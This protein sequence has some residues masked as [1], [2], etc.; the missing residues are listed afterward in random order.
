[1]A[2]ALQHEHDQSSNGGSTPWLDSPRTI[3]LGLIFGVVF[4]FLLQKGGVAKFDILIGVLLLEDFTVIKVMM[5]A[6]VVGLLGVPLLRQLGLLELHIKPTILG[7]NIVGGLIFG[8]GFALLAYCSGTDA[9][10][11]GQGNL[12]ALTGMA[13]MLAG[14][15]VFALA[16]RRLS[17]SFVQRGNLGER[18]V[19]QLVPLP[20]WLTHV[21]AAVVL[22]GVLLAIEALG[23]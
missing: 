17:S 10:A 1:M 8:V 22:A 21:I 16:S 12:D 20:A 15:Y 19:T 18:R 2:D 4:G 14:S 13:G 23:Y 3:V 6:V 9:A 11:V 7:S 5:S